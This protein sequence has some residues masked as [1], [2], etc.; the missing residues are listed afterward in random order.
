MARVVVTT[1]K[2]ERSSTARAW[3]TPAPPTTGRPRDPP[4]DPTRP[5]ALLPADRWWFRGGRPVRWPGNTSSGPR[6][7][8]RRAAGADRAHRWPCLRCRDASTPVRRPSRRPPTPGLSP[9][10]PPNNRR[11]A[12]RAV[13]PLEPPVPPTFRD[14]GVPADLAAV[15]DRRGIATPF[16][17]QAATLPD[18]LTGR[19]VSGKA[20]TG[21][22]KTL[23]FGIPLA[24]RAT[25]GRPRRPHSLVLAPTRELAA[26]I[27]SELRPLAA[28]RG[29]T[30]AAFYGG[31]GFGKQ[32]TALRQGVD[33]AVACPGR[34]ADLVQ[35]RECRLDEVDLVVIDEAD[36]MADMGFLPE[37]RRLL[38]KVR[39]DRQTLLFSA[40]LDDDV[41][42]LV[43]HYQ[44]DPARH[45]VGP[46]HQGPDRT[47]HH[48]W[49]TADDQRV[50][51]TARLVRH[52]GPTIV[53]CRTKRRADRV[54]RQLGRAGV[55]AAAI[56]GD[57]S[58][59]QRER[60]LDAFTRGKVE[61]LVAT[62]VAARGIHVTDVACV[63][64]YD[65]P[66][67]EK[68][69]VHRSGRTGRAGA[70]GTVVTLVGG[71]HRKAAT[72]L[73][74]TLKL[75]TDGT[76]APDLAGLPPVTGPTP[77]P[78]PG[79]AGPGRAHGR[80]GAARTHEQ[81]PKGGP[82]RGAK[83]GAKSGGGRRRAAHARSGPA[84]GDRGGA[85]ANRARRS[86]GS[87]NGGRPKGA[88]RR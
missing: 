65:L 54:T 59:S 60:A 16:P 18:A 39:P 37:V 80:G 85:P 86:G 73:Q 69:Y 50:D 11:S 9:P 67:D 30:V 82:P 58:Q 29:L 61:A 52:H 84:R 2:K 70:T 71:E 8:C 66:G 47:E 83:G 43:R 87:R 26:Q 27:E 23:A 51:L 15:L 35:R 7:G 74:R 81:R 19:D 55:S 49:H 31:V 78:T 62:D 5:A 38:D 14:L 6:C 88:P 13:A 32:L 28:V 76:V 17:V 68:D 4:R 45:E 24:V 36:R 34:L 20:P 56:H 57:R 40:T 64:H 12:P 33:I 1:S 75:T 25:S 46:L 63:V 77:A 48:F 42:V 53:F 3:P 22:G 44:R 10:R 72:R 79:D 41:A 21:S